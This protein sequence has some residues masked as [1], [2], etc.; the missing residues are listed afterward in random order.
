MPHVG[1]GFIDVPH[2]VRVHHQLAAGADFLAQNA[3]A[4]HVFIQIAADLLLE[5]RPAL[6]DAFAREAANLVVVVAEPARRGRVSRVA[7]REHLLLAHEG[8]DRAVRAGVGDEQMERVRT[9]IHRRD[10]HCGQRTGRGWPAGNAPV[11]C[12]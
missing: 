1:D 2:L 11:D 5:M 6:R 12:R 9:K 4:A 10:P 8:D 7:L 3:G